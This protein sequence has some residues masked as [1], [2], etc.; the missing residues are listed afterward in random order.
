MSQSGPGAPG[1]EVSRAVRTRS[2]WQA[3]RASGK[4]GLVGSAGLLGLGFLTGYLARSLDLP[5]QP[6]APVA[7]LAELD[8]TPSPVL[9]ARE[10]RAPDTDTHVPDDAAAIPALVT[11]PTLEAAATPS[12]RTGRSSPRT[13][14][15]SASKAASAAEGPVAPSPHDELAILV[16]AERA[17]RAGNAALAL[18][19]TDELA[20]LHPRSALVEERRAI[21]LLAYCEAGASDAS[22]RAARFLGDHPS[23]VYVGRIIEECPIGLGA[24]E[25]PASDKTRLNGH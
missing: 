18:A 12:R 19:L 22:A 16:R 17:V 11:R 10:S 6:A 4:V 25:L 9:T 20:R 23:S 14:A 3:L 5:A 15:A 2:R 13:A 24:R 1:L 8:L 7:Q 21:E